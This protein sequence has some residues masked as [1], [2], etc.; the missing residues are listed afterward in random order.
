MTF[1]GQTAH[2]A[3]VPFQQEVQ[4]REHRI[5]GTVPATLTDFKIDPPRF[6][7]IPIRN[8]IPVRVETSWQSE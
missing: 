4:D 8:E 6:L 2:Y 1:A 3:Q 7:T 5:R